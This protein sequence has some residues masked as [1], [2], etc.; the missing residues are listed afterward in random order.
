MLSTRP[1][2]APS[3]RHTANIFGSSHKSVHG[4]MK[5]HVLTQGFVNG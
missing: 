4:Q 2:R 3:D 1:P 5:E